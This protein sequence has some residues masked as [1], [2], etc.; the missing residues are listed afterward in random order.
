MFSKHRFKKNKKSHLKRWKE[1]I[2]F[3]CMIRLYDFEN[4]KKQI[5]V[6][7]FTNNE[8]ISLET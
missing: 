1:S 7:N 3:T 4:K 2:I 8:S 5:F 6:Y